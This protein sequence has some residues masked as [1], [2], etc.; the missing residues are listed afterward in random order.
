MKKILSILCAVLI[1]FSLCACGGNAVPAACE[2]LEKQAATCL[3]PAKCKACGVTFGAALGHSFLEGKCI[4]ANCKEQD[5]DWINW[6]T[7]GSVNITKAEAEEILSASFKKPKNVI[8][9]I[10]DGMGPNDIILTEKNKKGCFDF[11]LVLNL[12]KNTG[13]ATTRSYDSIVTDSAASGTALATGQKTNNGY[14]GMSPEGKPI[15]NVAEIAKEKG[16]RV[17]I[18][19]NDDI[20]GATPSAFAVHNISRK[21]YSELAVSF[22]KFKPDVLMGQGYSYFDNADLS[23]FLVSKDAASINS[24]LNRDPLCE[25]PF[26]GFFSEDI[27][28]EPNDTLAHLTEAALNRLKNDKGFFLMVESAGTDKAGHNNHIKGKVNSVVT[29]DRAVAVV[30]KFMKENPDTLLIITSDHE[31]GGVVLPKGE[32][33]LSSSLFTTDGHTNKDVR[34]FAVGYGAEYFSG[35]TVDNTNIG[36]FV[37]DAIKN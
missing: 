2:H 25:K 12:I 6:Y 1:I 15:K 10:G 23:A 32:F 37:I 8:V 28:K 4:R 30:L 5:P 26:I 16:K 31:T 33:K 7:K 22:A 24:V 17:G 21:N 14:V 29:L 35:K 20:I 19:T 11:G 34:T 36:K 3:E 18:V 27:I 9:M 13:F